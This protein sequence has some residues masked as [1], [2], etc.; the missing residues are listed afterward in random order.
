MSHSTSKRG[1]FIIAAGIKL[2]LSLWLLLLLGEALATIT[3]GGHWITWGKTFFV[4]FALV[5]CFGEGCVAGMLMWRERERKK[6]MN[7][8]KFQEQGFRRD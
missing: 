8:H 7:E 2:G 4:I 3:F 5:F 6:L 1:P